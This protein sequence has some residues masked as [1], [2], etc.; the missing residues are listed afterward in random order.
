MIDIWNLI[1][2]AIIV[3]FWSNIVCEILTFEGIELLKKE[4]VHLRKVSK[5]MKIFTIFEASVDVIWIFSRIFKNSSCDSSR[6]VG[7]NVIIIKE[8]MGEEL[9]EVSDSIGEELKNSDNEVW[10]G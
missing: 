6:D 9:D 1:Y 10:T 3:Q 2:L 8:S 5:S 7:D 4:D